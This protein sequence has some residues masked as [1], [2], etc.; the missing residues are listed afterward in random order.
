M[1][2]FAKLIKDRTIN[3]AVNITSKQIDY[4]NSAKAYSIACDESSDVN[5]IEQIALLCRYVNSDGPQEELIELIPLKGQMQGQDICKS[6]LS[7]LKPKRINTTHLVSVSTDGA[8]SMRGAQK[9][10]SSKVAGLRA[11]DISLHLALRST[12]RSNISP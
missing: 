8:P 11:D 6:V 3:M 9:N 5:D 12:V 2:P 1:P 10:L 4:I 7:C